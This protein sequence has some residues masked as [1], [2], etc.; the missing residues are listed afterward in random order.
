[1]TILLA[2]FSLKAQEFLI[3]PPE[4]THRESFTSPRGTLGAPLGVIFMWLSNSVGKRELLESD[5]SVFKSKICHILI[6]F[7]HQLRGNADSSYLR[8]LLRGYNRMMLES[9]RHCV[10]HYMRNGSYY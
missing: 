7:S 1:M 8:R 2:S 5:R 4:D 9:S 3:S 10:Y 6:E